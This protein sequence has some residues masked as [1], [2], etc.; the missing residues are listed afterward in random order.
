[1]VG[2]FVGLGVGSVEGIG[3]GDG[4]GINDGY[5]DG[6]L[7]VGK[8]VGLG[9]GT[10]DG[11]ILGEGLGIDDG[12]TLG[13]GVVG[14]SEGLGDGM[15]DG[16]GE[17]KG[18]VGKAVG[19]GVG[20][21]EGEGDGTDVGL[22]VGSQVVHVIVIDSISITDPLLE[23][24]Q[25]TESSG[26]VFL[27]FGSTCPNIASNPPSPSRAQLKVSSPSQYIFR[28]YSFSHTQC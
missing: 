12:D 16:L 19:L 23:T 25:L 5:D 10:A 21:D 6:T 22:G 1:M 11:L 17:G 24:F 8:E 28:K 13:M 7:V 27:Q 26:G 14:K 20:I 2:N 4:L 15:E 3:L 9:V 18:V